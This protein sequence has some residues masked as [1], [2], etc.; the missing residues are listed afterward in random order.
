MEITKGGK[1]MSDQE[2]V[3]KSNPIS[4]RIISTFISV[5]T[6]FPKPRKD[7]DFEE[8]QR[9]EFRSPRYNENSDQYSDQYRGTHL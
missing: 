2:K 1:V 3:K 9:I 4:K 8:W 6:A 5:C 7:L